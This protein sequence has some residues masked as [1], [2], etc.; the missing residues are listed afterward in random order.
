MFI[1]IFTTKEF[2]R[3]ALK[4]INTQRKRYKLSL[5]FCNLWQ[6][7]DKREDFAVVI[8]KMRILTKQTLSSHMPCKH[9]ESSRQIASFM[10]SVCVCVMKFSSWSHDQKKIS[11]AFFFRLPNLVTFLSLFFALTA[12]K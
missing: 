12:E 8:I 2:V 5:K 4:Y 10:A 7:F 3:I 1:A 9:W 11:E 6:D